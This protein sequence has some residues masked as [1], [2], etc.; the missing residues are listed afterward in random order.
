MS[1]KDLRT[2]L[3]PLKR[4]GD[5]A[6][7]T[8]KS[9]MLVKYDERKDREPL[10]FEYDRSLIDKTIDDVEIDAESNVIVNNIASV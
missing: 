5:K 7:P 10:S 9:D 2:I 3:K 8:K 1:I 6:L 4:N